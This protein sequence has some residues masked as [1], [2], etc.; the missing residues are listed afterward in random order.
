MT[1]EKDIEQYFERHPGRRMSEEMTVYPQA[2]GMT[3]KVVRYSWEGRNVKT[4]QPS[5]KFTPADK[6]TGFTLGELTELVDWAKAQQLPPE[7]QLKVQVTMG[8]RLKEVTV[9]A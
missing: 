3:D 7:T 2:A 6:K 8:S 9:G 5:V 4:L 1:D